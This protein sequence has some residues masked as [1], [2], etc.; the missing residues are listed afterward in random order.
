MQTP[1]PYSDIVTPRSRRLRTVGIVLI[2]A[3]GLMALYGYFGLMPTLDRNLHS[4]S[5]SAPAGTSRVDAADSVLKPHS[6]QK[7][8]RVHKLQVAVALAYWGI[9]ALL[10]VGAVGIAWLDFREVSRLFV[11]RRR[12]L[13]TQA[14]DQI[15]N[16][17]DSA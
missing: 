6:G 17:D 9:C 5:S 11:T 8:A 10:L 3:G 13:W 16:R 7:T 12:E 2:L 4:A 15:K 14:A 1:S